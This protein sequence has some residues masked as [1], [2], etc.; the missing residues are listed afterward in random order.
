M[1]STS[2]NY[3]S[4]GLHL[5][6]ERVS[7]VCGTSRVARGLGGVPPRAV[8]DLVRRLRVEVLTLQELTPQAAAGLKQAGL[9][10]LLPHYLQE[11]RDLSAGSGLYSRFPTRADKPPIELGGFFQVR[12]HVKVSTACYWLPR[13]R[14]CHRPRTA[15]HL[16]LLR[17]ASYGYSPGDARSCAG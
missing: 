16:A 15:R 6:R 13:C 14:R 1:F 3:K 5:T 2:R 7:Y 8:V 17:Y 10:R 12:A 9:T 4:P 11:A